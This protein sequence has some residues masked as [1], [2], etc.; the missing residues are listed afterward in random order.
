MIGMNAATGQIITDEIEH[1]RQS[2]AD[3]LMTPIGSR[4]HRRDYGSM[5]PRLIDRPMNSGGALMVYSAATHA[6][7]IHEPRI[8]LSRISLQ[9]GDLSGRAILN[10]EGSYANGDTMSLELPVMGVRSS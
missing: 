6:L 9:L 3:I 5:V 4:V 7:M 10:I 8:R 1:I 2:I